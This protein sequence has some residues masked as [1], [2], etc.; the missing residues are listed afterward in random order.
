[1]AAARGRALTWSVRISAP[2]LTPAAPK[3]RVGLS[4][5]FDA[6]TA[7]VVWD[8]QEADPRKSEMFVSAPIVWRAKVFIGIAFSDGA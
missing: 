3:G 4:A 2:Y 6:K 7:K 5:T 1:M 8:V